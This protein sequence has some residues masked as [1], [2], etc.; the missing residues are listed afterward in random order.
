MINETINNGSNLYYVYVYT[1][2]IGASVTYKDIVISYTYQV[3][4]APAS[5]TFTDVP[6]SH[7]FFQHIEALVSSGVTSGC[8]SSTYCPNTYVAREQMA[9]FLVN[10]FNL[11]L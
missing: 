4:P 7:I 8:T 5:P 2:H 10:S 6:T 11:S 1:N 9:K 3:A